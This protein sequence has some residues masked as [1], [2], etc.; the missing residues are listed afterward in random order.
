M[1]QPIP[2]IKNGLCKKTQSKGS[3]FTFWSKRM[4]MSLKFDDQLLLK[5]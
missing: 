2:L 1:D 3:I 5:D 4:F